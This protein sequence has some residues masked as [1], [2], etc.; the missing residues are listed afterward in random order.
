MEITEIMGKTTRAVD[1]VNDTDVKK[2]VDK[3]TYEANVTINFNGN[4]ADIL[5]YKEKALK[6]ELSALYQFKITNKNLN[7]LAGE[8]LDLEINVYIT[9]VNITYR[10]NVVDQLTFKVERA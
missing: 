9:N 4:V 5:I 1:N 10:N 6:A 2:Q 3:G 8:N 7:T